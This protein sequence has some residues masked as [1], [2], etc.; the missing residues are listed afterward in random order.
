MYGMAT[1]GLYAAY[2]EMRSALPDAPVVRALV[3]RH[4]VR[5][6]TA[7]FLRRTADRLDAQ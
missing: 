4:P 1:P 5:H 3:R 7:R 6:A 2:Q